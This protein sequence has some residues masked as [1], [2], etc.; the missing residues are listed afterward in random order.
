MTLPGP[1]SASAHAAVVES[2]TTEDPENDPHTYANAG[3]RLTATLREVEQPDVGQSLWELDLDVARPTGAPV[4]LELEQRVRTGC[5]TASV[6]VERAPSLA[7]PRLVML[8]LR[9]DNGEDFLSR[10]VVTALLFVAE[11]PSILWQGSG[12]YSNQMDQCETVDVPVFERGPNGT[13]RVVQWFEVLHHPPENASTRALPC[14][15]V[16]RR[17][18]EMAV[19]PMPR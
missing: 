12:T 6:V 2:A 18:L 19:L 4:T 7:D 8:N 5:G 3:F 13:I 14:K 9:C 16:A 1:A 10:H 11:P 15:A 17:D